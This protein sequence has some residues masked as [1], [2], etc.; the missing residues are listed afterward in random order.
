[1]LLLAGVLAPAG[2]SKEKPPAPVVAGVTVFP[3]LQE[4]FTTASPEL[5]NI[6]YEVNMAARERDYSRALTALDKLANAPGLTEPQKQVVGEVIGQ[7][8]QFPA[9]PPIR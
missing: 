7:V 4:A 8:K 2:C 3:K 6:V 1:M 9:T 5:T